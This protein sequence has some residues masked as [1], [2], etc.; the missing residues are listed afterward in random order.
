MNFSKLNDSPMFRQQLQCMEESSESLRSRCF[1]FYKGCRKYT[2]GLGEAYDGDIAFASALESFGGGHSDPLFVTLGG[3]VMTKFS[4][5]LREI[6]TYKELLRSQAEHVLND[7]LLNM[8]N[9]DMLDVKEARR[10]FEKASLVYDQAR[11][12]FMSLR[13]STR[14]DIATVVEE[15]LHNARSSFEEARFNLVSALHNVEAKKRFEFLEAVTGVMDAHLRY[16]R[17]GYQLLHELE[18]FIIEVLAYTQK[19]RESYNDEQISLCERMLEYKKHVHHES[20][21]SLNG[22]YISPRGDGNP[23][24]PFSRISN[25]VADAVTESAENGKVQILRQGYL[26][27]RSSN[28]RGDWKRRYFV[29][30]SRGMLYYFRKPWNG[31]HSSNQ[32]SVHRNCAAD[33]SAGILSRLL[34]SHN[35]GLLLPDEKSVARH[36]VNLLTSTIKTDAEQT[37]L[38]FCFRIISP[39]KSYTLQAENAVDQ[40]DWMEKITGVIASLLSAQ[41]LTD[42]SESGYCYSASN[43]YLL[44]GP[45][46]D[47]SGSGD[48]IKNEKPIDVLRKVGGNDK[49]ADCGK[50]DPDWASLNLGI[51]VC[52]E[53]SGVH[54]NLGVHLSK[55]RSLTLDVKIWDSSV[56][57]MFQSLGNLFANSVWEELLHSSS[58]SQ[59][60]E[61]LDGSSKPQRKLFHARKP[62]H[63]DPISLKERFI[64]AKYSAKVFV[65]QTPN[66]NRLLSTAQQVV[67]SISANDKKAVYRHIIKSDVDV[68]AIS[69]EVIYGFCTSMPSSPNPNM[70]YESKTQLAKDIQDGSSV[71][72]LACLTSD[73]AMVE[74]LLHYGADV[75]AIDSKGRTPLHYCIMR[76]KTANARVLITRG[77]NPNAVDK[78]GKT[79]HKLAPEPDTVGKDIL[80][81]QIACPQDSMEK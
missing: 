58:T 33:N 19:A 20:M 41:T 48:F 16:Y 26:S 59:T 60:D 67:E 3:P 22:P 15:E 23:V 52:I 11:E 66:N 9:V 30:D 27:K 31:L 44:K 32:A 42:D 68:N 79:P 34:S 72:H 37:D 51:L 71:L 24:Q 12:K 69:S 46:D 5:A 6:S 77:A 78:E 53:C 2:E 38:R 54:R 1:K 10:R 75:N 49:C 21:L 39:A 74:M 61:T 80:N 56:L 81:K 45:D 64:H 76:G 18:P 35:H 28:L 7:R 55:V 13:K 50:P 40:M 36:T 14:M 57:T 17:Q 47:R 70:S 62:S 73:A 4:I 29:L 8:L 65:R 43:L 63:D 25:T